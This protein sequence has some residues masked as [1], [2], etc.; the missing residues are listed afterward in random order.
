MA[1]NLDGTYSGLKNAIA[2]F[3]NRNDTA[4]YV[5]DLI[6]LAEDRIYDEIR[7]RELE[8][9]FS[10][11][12]TTA[13]GLATLPDGFLGLKHVW[14]QDGSDQRALEICSESWLHGMYPQRSADD[15]PEVCAVLAGPSGAN[16]LEFGP[17]PASNGTVGGVCYQRPARL[18]STTNG[19]FQ[20]HQGL[21]LFASLS[22]SAIKVGQD[23]RIPVW[24]AK[25]QTNKASI[26][27]VEERKDFSGPLMIRVG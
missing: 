12:I 6:V 18:S 16:Y 15:D 8:T 1:L 19:F 5:E 21:F 7:S 2:S 20:A 4:D 26:Q 24:E 13:T 17:Y 10:I 25:Y 3:L 27:L 14:I 9:S 23:V 22:E 11:T